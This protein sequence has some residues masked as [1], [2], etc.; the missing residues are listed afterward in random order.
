MGSYYRQQL[1]DYLKTVDVKAE[2]V[3]DVGGKQKPVQGRT[4]TWNVKEYQILDIPEYDLNNAQPSRRQGDF[5]F[6]LEVFEYL[7]DPVTAIKNISSLL[8]PGGRA[9]VSFAFVYPYHNEIEWDSLRYT[10]TGVKRL[11]EIGSLKVE[12]VHRRKTKT[13]SLTKYYAEDGMRPVKGY[14]HN[15]TGFIVELR[16]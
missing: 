14:D 2:M 4:K 9:I 13:G 10:E 5:V 15:V 12:K 11:A 3:Y 1:E 6:C 8:H 16:K 7:I